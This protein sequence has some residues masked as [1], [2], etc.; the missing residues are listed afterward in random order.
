[1]TYPS[2]SIWP[3]DVSRELPQIA[4]I[5]G[6]DVSAAQYPHREWLP[7]NIH[8][9][10]QDIFAPFPSDHVGQYDVVHMRFFV[11][12]LDPSNVQGLLENLMTLLKPGGYLQWVDCDVSSC[13]VAISSSSAPSAAMEKAAAMTRQ[14]RPADDYRSVDTLFP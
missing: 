9:H 3:T 11:T 8:L 6:F 7:T 1:M 4:R 10:V 2:K 12:L 5:D 13:G 14:P